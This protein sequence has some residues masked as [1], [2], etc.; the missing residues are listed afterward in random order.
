MCSIIEDTKHKAGSIEEKCEVEPEL[1]FY[2]EFRRHDNYKGEYGFDW[3]RKDYHIFSEYYKRLKSEYTKS[4]EEPRPNFN[5]PETKLEGKEYFVPWLSL[6]PLQTVELTLKVFLLEGTVQST[7]VIH[8]SNPKDDVLFSEVSLGG[9]DK[10]TQDIS[11]ESLF[12][13]I[14]DKDT[15]DIRKKIKE[16]VEEEVEEIKEEVKEEIKNQKEFLKI[17][18]TTTDYNDLKEKTAYD[19]Y[20]D[21]SL[22]EGNYK[23]NAAEA[24]EI[25]LKDI[26]NDL[27][28]IEERETHPPTQQEIE[29]EIQRRIK[30]KGFL[31][32]EIKLTATC[33]NPLVKHT[34]ITAY[35]KKNI[36]VGY[37][38]VLKNSNHKDFEFEITP[39]RVLRSN[40]INEA[41]QLIED[42]RSKSDL[43]I[44]KN[45]YIGNKKLEDFLNGSSLNQ[46]LL[47]NVI[48]KPYEIFIDEADWL[49][50]SYITSNKQGSLVFNKELDSEIHESVMKSVCSQHKEFST[51][52]GVF[53]FL[54][55]LDMPLDKGKTIMGTGSKDIIQAHDLLIYKA[56]LSDLSVFAHETAH[57]LG[58]EHSFVNKKD[59]NSFE[60][61]EEVR[62]EDYDI[63]TNKK[64]KKKIKDI[65]DAM[66]RAKQEGDDIDNKYNKLNEGKDITDEDY[67][68]LS[69][70]DKLEWNK[71]LK[72]LAE[73]TAEH[74]KLKQ[75]LKHSEE[76]PD[77][78]RSRRS[79][80]Q[81]HNPHKFTQSCTEN[82]MDYYNKEKSFWKFQW[83]AMQNDVKKFYNKK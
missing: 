43:K 35:N 39:I 61:R 44:I 68:V 71:S 7:D 77:E 70:K 83:L 15:Q 13:G 26:K 48:T 82:F 14:K 46:A 51:R 79:Y 37:L 74:N 55:P 81:G 47:K 11:L 34:L 50:K 18:K 27:E 64:L 16:E 24:K 65:E 21:A 60:N 2:V 29:Q 12:P 62:R 4:T 23:N 20:F 36:P 73:L 59:F 33:V 57:V 25:L 69:D 9:K 53:M 45:D 10:D 28:E 40:T 63:L 80:Y 5:L 49:K 56:A 67:V 17:V 19:I 78:Y 42:K 76:N 30:E 66:V 1:K 52:R 54:M 6:F 58:L 3:M 8:L 41:D 38:K 31:T 32:K 72:I 75:K 22:H